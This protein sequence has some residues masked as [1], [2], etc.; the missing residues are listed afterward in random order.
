MV[1]SRGYFGAEQ[2]FPFE[3][4]HQA[5]P[6]DQEADWTGLDTRYIWRIH[7]V[8]CMVVMMIMMLLRNVQSDA[9][10]GSKPYNNKILESP[11]ES[12]RDKHGPEAGGEK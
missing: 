7:G 4:M 3:Y 12:K 1:S 5:G 10:S 6:H 8:C 11:R 9:G 2:L